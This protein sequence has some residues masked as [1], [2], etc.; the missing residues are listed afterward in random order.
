MD[1]A[2][3]SIAKMTRNTR[4]IW[5]K[6]TSTPCFGSGA[7]SC[8]MG[9]EW[10]VGGLEGDS[11]RREWK[12]RV[13]GASGGPSAGMTER[14]GVRKSGC[15]L[16]GLLSCSNHRR[17]AYR[18][19][20]YAT[21][22]E[23]GHPAPPCPYPH[24][25]EAPSRMQ[26]QPPP[27]SRPTPSPPPARSLVPCCNLDPARLAALTMTSSAKSAQKVMRNTAAREML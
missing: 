26:I 19:C 25:Q 23:N 3:C 16:V 1:R 14:M 4:V 2:V 22:R 9:E 24:G 10:E 27:A 18:M 7:P 12:T 11:G 21:P 17:R 6:R 8:T 5:A 13:E 15:W 20:T